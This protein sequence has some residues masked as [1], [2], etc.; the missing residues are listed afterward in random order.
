[1]GK[2]T[3]GGKKHK[4]AKNHTEIK[5]PLQLREEGECY[6]KVTKTLGGSRL[7]CECYDYSNTKNEF[8]KVERICTIRG[9]MRKRVWMK[10]EDIV[11]VSIREFVLSEHKGTKKDKGDIIWKYKPDEVLELKRKED[12]P[13]FNNETEFEDTNFNVSDDESKINIESDENLDEI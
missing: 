7:L 1:M 4:R 5:R 10:V 2:N 3:I 6:A 13:T 12:F 11:L 9:S 8:K